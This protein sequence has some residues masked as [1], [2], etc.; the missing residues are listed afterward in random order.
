MHPETVQ[1]SAIMSIE[2]VPGGDGQADIE[3]PEGYF[4]RIAATLWRI[5]RLA[6]PQILDNP[7]A[8][9][10]F[11]SRP[12]LNGMVSVEIGFDFVINEITEAPEPVLYR[13]TVFESV[14]CEIPKDAVN[15][16]WKRFVLNPLDRTEVYSSGSSLQVPEGELWLTDQPTNQAFS[17]DDYEDYVHVI[18]EIYTMLKQS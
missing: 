6:A 12:I 7:Y 11:N 2:R 14:P 18:E 15:T 9:S 1:Y 4:D 8:P 17:E 5:G 16:S 3:L 10:S 13:G